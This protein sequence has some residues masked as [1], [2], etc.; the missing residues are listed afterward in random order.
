MLNSNTIKNETKGLLET[1][2]G[3]L[4]NFERMPRHIKYDQNDN[5]TAKLNSNNEIIVIKEFEL[6]ALEYIVSAVDG[7]IIEAFKTSGTL[8]DFSD[9]E[10]NNLS[11][12]DLLVYNGVD[13]VNTSVSGI[14]LSGSDVSSN[15]IPLNYVPKS[16]GIGGWNSTSIYEDSER[17][18]KIQYGTS[19]NE[20]STDGTLGGNSDLALPTEKAVKTYIDNNVIVNG[21]FGNLGTAG[22]HA[23]FAA[24]GLADSLISETGTTINASCDDLLIPY[25]SS[26]LARIMFSHPTWPTVWQNGIEMDWAAVPRITNV[27]SYSDV[28]D[29][30][31]TLCVGT[32]AAPKIGMMLR[33]GAGGDVTYDGNIGFGTT[34]VGQMQNSM[35]T[36]MRSGNG[37][38]EGSAWPGMS[39]TNTLATKGDGVTTF[40]FAGLKFNAGNSTVSSIFLNA[41]DDIYSGMLF[42][43]YSNHP[44][45]VET[46]GTI[47][48]TWANDGVIT[49]NAYG[50]GIIHSSAAGVLTSSAIV[51]GDITNNTITNNQLANLGTQNK[52]VKFGATGLADSILIEAAGGIEIPTAKYF[53]LGAAKGRITL[54]D[55]ATDYICFMDCNVGIGTT[56]PDSLLDVHGTITL[57]SYGVLSLIPDVNVNGAARTLRFNYSSDSLS[58]GFQFYNSDSST[59]LVFI[60]GDG[61]VGINT[62]TPAALVDIKD[63]SLYFTDSDCAHGVTTYLPTDVYG[64]IHA[65]SATDGGLDILGISD[66]DNYGLSLRGM[67]GDNTPALAPVRLVAMKKNGTGAQDLEYSELAYSFTNRGRQVASIYGEGNLNLYNEAVDA[68]S[69]IL[70]FWKE[71]NGYADITPGDIVGAIDFQAMYSSSYTKIARIEVQHINAGGEDSNHSLLNFYTY[72]YAGFNKIMHLNGA[73]ESVN[74]TYNLYVGRNGHFVGNIE[75]DGDV[76]MY[77]YIT[78]LSYITT[79]TVYVDHIAEHTNSHGI[80]FNHNMS[81]ANKNLSS[82][83]IDLADDTAT[84]FTPGRTHG[85][86]LM[87]C[88]NTSI[89]VVVGYEV[90]AT[91]SITIIAQNGTSFEVTTGALAGTTGS[92]AKFTLS[93]HTDGKIYLENRL[94]GT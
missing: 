65:A 40:N 1:S 6:P 57:G 49:F 27:F 3:G 17:K 87:S 38:T 7:G 9:V 11:K 72:G 4:F 47:R 8:D 71:R 90:G 2:A 84:S 33:G 67:V 53:G 69:D 10:Y 74:I 28:S 36:C 32:R 92:D 50:L 54:E 5:G 14:N 80:V 93:T 70:T 91:P 22:V 55:A 48:Q 81:S 75:I 77:G 68:T 60:R 45:A 61:K 62:T 29:G 85:I 12:N 46:N 86:M 79:P 76:F 59:N 43:T 89:G 19:I 30:L 24:T 56:N 37:A 88:Q 44:T 66:T 18:I 20:F 13:W 21:D 23:K 83:T 39:F 15:K 52:L 31:I 94:G 58:E 64:S 34:T 41:Y 51:A 42:G 78:A 63:G 16:D 73:D 26:S 35:I 82:G 25:T